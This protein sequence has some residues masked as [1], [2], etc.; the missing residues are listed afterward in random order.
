ML[1]YNFLVININRA[2]IVELAMNFQDKIDRRN[3]RSAFDLAYTSGSKSS[4]FYFPEQYNATVRVILG[5]TT[6]PDLLKERFMLESKVFLFR[7]HH[8]FFDVINRKLQQYIEGDLVNYNMKKW[9]ESSNPRMY[10][11]YKE[12][13]AVLLLGELES[14]FVVSLLPFAL[15]IIMFCFEW[16][17]TLKNLIVV[18]YIFKAFYAEKQSEQELFAEDRLKKIKSNAHC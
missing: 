18:Q 1:L 12:P 6:P 14:G 4:S 2:K 11:E 16:I 10:D 9:L 13:F 8:F 3:F 17:P 7:P 15:A 5:R